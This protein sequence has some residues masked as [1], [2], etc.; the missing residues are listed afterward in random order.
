M[1]VPELPA[2]RA[3]QLPF[4][5]SAPRPAIFTVSFSIFTVAPRALMQSSVLWQSAAAA[6]WRSSLVPSAI[7]ASMAYRWEMDLSP[8]GST[9]PVR[10][11]AG[12]MVCFFTA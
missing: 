5:P 10:C 11:F 2:S 4:R 1:V 12:C 6:K 8:G 9:P 3:R 7:A